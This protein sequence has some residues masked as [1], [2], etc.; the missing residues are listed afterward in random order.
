MIEKLVEK[1]EAWLT[2]WQGWIFAPKTL[3]P[4][5]RN[6][7]RPLTFFLWNVL[8]AYLVAVVATFGFL[9]FEHQI[10]VQR[11]I[12]E[13]ASGALTITTGMF[14][15]YAA[16]TFFFYLIASLISYLSF[17]LASSKIQFK[18]HFQLF[19]E[20]SFLEPL[21]LFTAS[22]A[23]LVWP[24]SVYSSNTTAI[25]VTLVSLLLARLW[26]FASSYFPLKALHKLPT[27]SHKKAFFSGHFLGVLLVGF[28]G[29]L[30]CWF[31]LVGLV[32]GWE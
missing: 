29:T 13:E 18:E 15:A 31:V 5:D 25:S 27:R 2:R 26:A 28:L 23:M 19:L 17:R 21:F 10:L 6:S 9:V 32:A 30:V 22:V 7:V 4:R 3:Y 16:A 8:L 24:P 14:L 11:R 20:L 12:S 1:F